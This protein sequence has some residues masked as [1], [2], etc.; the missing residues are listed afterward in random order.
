M[1]RFS[2]ALL[3]VGDA[4]E[5]P[6]VIEDHDERLVLLR[7]LVRY[8]MIVPCEVAA[9]GCRP[10]HAKGNEKQSTEDEVATKY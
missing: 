10:L 4:A 8:R 3:E 5:G 6:A 2:P 7:L 9:V 1:Q